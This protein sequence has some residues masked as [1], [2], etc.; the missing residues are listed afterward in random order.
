MSYSDFL[1]LEQ[2]V[3]EARTAGL[4]V[5]ERTVKFYTTRGL[6][7]KP[8][9]A[10]YPGADGRV[11]Y[12]PATALR[13]L[14]RIHQLKAQGFTLEQ[15][16]KFLEQR[17]GEPL[18]QLTV[19]GPDWRREVVYHFLK[20]LHGDEAR[21]AR[22]EFA[23]KMVDTEDEMALQ[24]ASRTYLVRLAAALVGE[25][26]A[27]RY[28]DEFLLE[29]PLD[30]REKRMGPFREWRARIRKEEQE[31]QGDAY[32]AFRRFTSDRLLGLTPPDV[33]REEIQ[34][35]RERFEALPLEAPPQDP[36]LAER[37]REARRLILAGLNGL[38]EGAEGGSQVV[39]KALELFERGHRLLQLVEQIASTHLQAMS[40][41]PS[42]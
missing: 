6:L 18:R 13:K 38:H 31:R 34:A 30:E 2:L 21:R 42:R 28:V 22:V 9:K 16:A 1:S 32:L 19:A 24:T 26:A 40:T 3:Q 14:R 10:P 17:A 20:N 15:I 27:I 11:S 5:S 29:L 39:A 8:S 4:D 7:P 37:M 23:T 35:V 41:D 36:I 25:S 33:F 12:Y